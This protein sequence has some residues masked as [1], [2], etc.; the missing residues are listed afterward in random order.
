[1]SGDY[2]SG[3]DSA[4]DL[5]GEAMNL[6]QKASGQLRESSAINA[7]ASRAREELLEAL[8]KALRAQTRLQWR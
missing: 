8:G 5:I 7:E 6:L 2:Y 3:W 1:M 4:H